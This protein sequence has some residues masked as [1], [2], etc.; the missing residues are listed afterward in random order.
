[1]EWAL[2]TSTAALVI[3][4]ILLGLYWLFMP[5]LVCNKLSRIVKLIEAGQKAHALAL[6]E[7]RATR[8]VLEAAHNITVEEG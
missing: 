8:K 7:M 2:L 4:A 6:Y 3:V 5:V 1:M